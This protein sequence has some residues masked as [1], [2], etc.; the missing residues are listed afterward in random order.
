MF[1]C[2]G[3][4]DAPLFR[5][6]DG[7]LLFVPACSSVIDYTMSAAILLRDQLN[8]NHMW[9]KLDSELIRPDWGESN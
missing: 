9:E 4:G 2:M 1:R 5:S 8:E 6:G 3:D 7:C